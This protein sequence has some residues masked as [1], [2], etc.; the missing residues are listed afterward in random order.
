MVIAKALISPFLPSHCWGSFAKPDEG[1]G[2]ATGSPPDS[3]ICPPARFPVGLARVVA[4]QALKRAYGLPVRFLR[5]W[6][7][8]ATFFSSLLPAL[9]LAAC[10]RVAGL[11]SSLVLIVATR[12]LKSR[13]CFSAFAVGAVLGCGRAGQPASLLPRLATFPRRSSARVALRGSAAPVGHAEKAAPLRG[14]IAL[15]RFRCGAGGRVFHRCGLSTTGDFKATE[16]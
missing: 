9:A 13:S 3:Q 15:D 5:Q 7:G 12:P 4:S 8:L 10:V 6:L 16:P 14:S 2:V 11:G 1:S